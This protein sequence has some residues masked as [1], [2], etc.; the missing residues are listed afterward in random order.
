[1]SEHDKTPRGGLLPLPAAARAGDDFRKS[2]D[3]LIA[4]ASAAPEAVL[5]LGVAP[6]SPSEREALEAAFLSAVKAHK[7][8]RPNLRHDPDGIWRC[9]ECDPVNPIRRAARVV[10]GAVRRR[11]RR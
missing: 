8:H 9:P 3:T 6:H 5:R 7:S 4:Q 1:M 11:R 2:M 10:V